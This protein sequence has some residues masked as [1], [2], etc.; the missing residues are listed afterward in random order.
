MVTA[1]IRPYFEIILLERNI[2]SW[3]FALRAVH[4]V[5]LLLRFTAYKLQ[6]AV[7]K[8]SPQSHNVNRPL[9]LDQ[10]KSISLVA[11]SFGMLQMV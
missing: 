2:E 3:S 11:Y 8:L 7:N 1:F 6:V 9:F 10:M 4:T 5:Q